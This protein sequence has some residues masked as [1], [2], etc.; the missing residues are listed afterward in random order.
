METSGGAKENEKD[1]VDND[2]EIETDYED[3]GA[4]RQFLILVQQ[5]KKIY[6]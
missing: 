4:K 6:F 3:S 2:E 5:Y 1:T